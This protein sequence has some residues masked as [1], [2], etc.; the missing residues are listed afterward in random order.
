MNRQNIL[1]MPYPVP[2]KTPKTVVLC[3]ACMNQSVKPAVPAVPPPPTV[4]YQGDLSGFTGRFLDSDYVQDIQ[5]PIRTL[6]ANLIKYDAAHD[7]IYMMHGAE[8]IAYDGPSFIARLIAGDPLSV[9]PDRAPLPAEIWLAWTRNYYAEH[10]PNWVP[11]GYLP[12]GQNYFQDFD[13]DDR[14]NIYMAFSVFWG[15]VS[16][17]LGTTTGGLLTPVTVEP[18]SNG[19]VQPVQTI[20]CIKTSDGHYYAIVAATE[21]TTSSVYDVTIPA[22][23]VLTGTTLNLVILPNSLARSAEQ[24]T[25]ALVNNNTHGVEIYTADGLVTGGSP[26]ATFSPTL[27]YCG[28]TSDGTNFYSANRGFTGMSISTFS[29]S[30]QTYAEQPSPVS[31]AF[32]PTNIRYGN[33]LLSIVGSAGTAYDIRVFRVPSMAELDFSAFLQ[34]STSAPRYFQAYYGAS[35]VPTG[36][37]NPEEIAFSDSLIY[38][39]GGQT[40]LIANMWG[41]GDVYELT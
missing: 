39:T 19:P 10:N 22:T 33:G 24:S 36:Y 14:A 18:I 23:P 30:G 6:R 7:R 37:L 27:E 1:A 8:M 31:G 4:G 29:P 28:M 9:M 41:I 38:T 12:D 32:S 16:D 17:D 25:I 11:G 20:N 40:Y 5:G 34:D 21:G 15:I 35:A 2:A 13:V 26:I 3:T